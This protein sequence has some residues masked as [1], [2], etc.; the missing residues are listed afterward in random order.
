MKMFDYN[1]KDIKNHLKELR[2]AASK[3]SMK[4]IRKT[5]REVNKS[6][7]K[8]VKKHFPFM[9]KNRNRFKLKSYKKLSASY[10]VRRP[11][12]S[13]L[14]VSTKPISL[15]HMIK[16]LPV[17]PNQKGVPVKRRRPVRYRIA[18]KTVKL[19]KDMFI[20]QATKRKQTGGI[21]SAVQVFWS[22]KR[23]GI[24]GKSKQ[25]WKKLEFLSPFFLLI[26]RPKQATFEK[27]LDEQ[28][29]NAYSKF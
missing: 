25:K 27:I 11:L 13:V 4:A 3:A 1:R 14:K 23:R 10:V 5:N 24:F 28:I 2:K 16:G 7:Y 19:K 18:G 21:Y 12:E 26:S 6:S 20:A 29:K 22:K 17:P 15:I 8:F 9:K